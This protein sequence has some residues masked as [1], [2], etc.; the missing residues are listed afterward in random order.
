MTAGREPLSRPSIRHGEARQTFTLPLTL[1]TARAASEIA[2]A[3]NCTLKEAEHRVI[4]RAGGKAGPVG[5]PE[6]RFVSCP[7]VQSACGALVVK[8]RARRSAPERRT[9]PSASP[10]PLFVSGRCGVPPLRW[11]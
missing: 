11:V 9:G 8:R 6:L 10:A 5:F 1:A 4:A 7:P 3:R 2:K